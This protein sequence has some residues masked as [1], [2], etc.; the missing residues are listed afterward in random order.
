MHA[1]AAVAPGV[2]VEQD[3]LAARELRRA[4]DDA[5]LA[6]DLA[7]FFFEDDAALVDC[8]FQRLFNINGDISED[9][10]LIRIQAASERAHLTDDD[11]ARADDQVVI[12]REGDGAVF[13]AD[14]AR[15]RNEQRQPRQ[16]YFTD[17]VFH[18]N[19]RRRT[20]AAIDIAEACEYG[21]RQLESAELRKSAE[22]F[23]HSSLSTQY[24]FGLSAA[25][26]TCLRVGGGG[27]A[28][29]GGGSASAGGLVS[30]SGLPSG[31]SK[32]G[33]TGSTGLSPECASQA[34]VGC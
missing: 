21:K 33:S 26:L 10:I 30:L 8:A 9:A 25:F 22:R 7:A 29:S 14:A 19:S 17:P 18:T 3:A 16:A 4:V 32:P 31:Y 2:E 34:S 24:G 15:Q 27:A 12:V 28:S 11:S 1:Q 20:G 5:A 6:C 13:R 23:T